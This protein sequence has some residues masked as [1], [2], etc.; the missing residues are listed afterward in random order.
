MKRTMIATFAAL[1]MV[2]APALAVTNAAPP[3][4]KSAKAEAKAQAKANKVAQ[5]SAAK[6]A[7]LAAKNAKKTS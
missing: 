6:S 4:T 3:T 5:K 7:K 2:A 1:S